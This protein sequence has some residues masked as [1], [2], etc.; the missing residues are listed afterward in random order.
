MPCGLMIVMKS[1]RAVRR[2]RSASGS[3]ARLGRWTCGSAATVRATV[4][5]RSR[6]AVSVRSRATSTVIS[7]PAATVTATTVSWRTSSRPARVRTR[8]RPILHDHNDGFDHN[9]HKRDTARAG[10]YLRAARKRRERREESAVKKQLWFW[11]LVAIA[12]GIVF[13]LVA[14]GP[15]TDSKWLPGALPPLIKTGT[16]PASFFS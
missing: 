5:E 4:S 6:A 12:A 1:T 10:S 8:M 14:P 7:A 13:G 2:R 15:A 9:D 11:V 16:P 3:S